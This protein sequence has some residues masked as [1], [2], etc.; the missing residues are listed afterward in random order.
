MVNHTKKR[1]TIKRIMRYKGGAAEQPLNN[2]ELIKNYKDLLVYALSK[3]NKTIDIL[4]DTG[5]TRI[6]RKLQDLSSKI[7]GDFRSYDRPDIVIK[8]IKTIVTEILNAST[9]IPEV[10]PKQRVLRCASQIMRSKFAHFQFNVSNNINAHLLKKEWLSENYEAKL[11]KNQER[12]RM[13][14]NTKT[15]ISGEARSRTKKLPTSGRSSPSHSRSSREP[16]IW[17]GHL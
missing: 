11:F 5:A 17:G 14:H 2:D 8:Q 1:K 9:F 13:L 12:V 15:S 6:A 4:Y 16:S 10:E 7:R 3:L